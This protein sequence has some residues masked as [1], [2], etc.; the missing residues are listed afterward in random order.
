[1]VYVYLHRV[2]YSVFWSADLVKKINKNKPIK[3]KQNNKWQNDQ[4]LS[5]NKYAYSN[6]NPPGG[7]LTSNMPY[8]TYKYMYN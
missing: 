5:I 3:I 2:F 6:Y 7:I 8:G 1:M 4:I